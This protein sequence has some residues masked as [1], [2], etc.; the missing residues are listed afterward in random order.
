M[1]IAGL[2]QKIAQP[3]GR[4]NA[5]KARLAAEKDPANRAVLCRLL[6]RIGDD[7]AL[8]LLRQALADAD[9]PVADAAA[10]ALADWPTAGGEGR[11]PPARPD[12][13]E[14]RRSKSWPCGPTSG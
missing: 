10:R 8:P 1:A 4:S 12:L 2:A 13:E 14:R 7:S 11:R 6:G 5:V 3:D 9:P